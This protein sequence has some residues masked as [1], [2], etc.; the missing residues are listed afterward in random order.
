[1]GALGGSKRESIS[2]PVKRV[3]AGTQMDTALQ[4]TDGVD[5]DL[6]TLGQGFLS[7]ASSAATPLE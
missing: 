5:A 3:G 4:S 6:G 1:V 7:Q 2:Q